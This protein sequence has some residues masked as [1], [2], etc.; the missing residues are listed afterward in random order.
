VLNINC[1][2]RALLFLYSQGFSH[3]QHWEQVKRDESDRACRDSAGGETVDK[4]APEIEGDAVKVDLEVHY[5]QVEGF[6]PLPSG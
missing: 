4:D 2:V 5:V 1:V 3:I 6:I